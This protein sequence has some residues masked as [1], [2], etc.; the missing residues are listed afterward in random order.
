[1]KKFSS[2]LCLFLTAFIWGF[3]FVFQERGTE[4][5][6]AFSF[7]GIRFLVGTVSLIPVA[8]IFEGRLFKTGKV[9]IKK[10]IPGWLVCGTALCIASSLQQFG[11][12]HTGSAGLAGFI[13]AI[14]TVLTPIMYF[15]IFRR[16]TKIQI[17]IGAVLAV[18]GLS[19][20][21]F[22]PGEGLSFGLGEWLLLIGAF[23]WATHMITVDYFAKELPSLSF[24]AGQ[25]AVCTI[26]SIIAMLVFESDTLSWSAVTAV[27]WDILYCGV[28]SVGIAYTLQIVGQ[29]HSDPT[30]AAIV[31]SLESVFSAVGGAL[32]GID[33]ISLL[34]YIGCAVIFAGIVISQLSFGKKS[35]KKAEAP[36]GP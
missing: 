1:M 33:S 19:L 21:C 4:V 7:N 8:L 17:W 5:L 28:M 18:T 20:L 22:K 32:F 2:T 13:T 23:F 24:A 11:I 26:I 15:L 10:M 14:Y 12:K 36:E 30:F 34:G 35:D 9:K 29:K 25:F 3:A 6:D 27:K 31:F 16:K